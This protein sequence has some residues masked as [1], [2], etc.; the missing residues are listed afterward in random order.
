MAQSSGFDLPN[1]ATVQA[2][3]GKEANSVSG[4]P[5]YLA[6][7]NVHINPAIGTVV[8]SAGQAITGI[9]TD[10]DGDLRNA[11]TPDIGADEGNFTI[12][13]VNDM[14]ATAFVNP[15]NGGALGTS[16][17]S[18]Q[19]SFSNNGSATQ[20]SVTVR[21]RIIDSLSVEVYNQ[22]SVIASI[23][24][25]NTTVVTFPS[26]SL[27]IGTYTIKAKSELGTDQVL[28]NDEI[29]GTVTVEPPLTGTKTVGA[30][31]DFATLTAAFAKLNSVGIDR[32]VTLSLTAATYGVGETFPLVLNAVQGAGPLNTVTIKPASGNTVTITGSSTSC[33][34][35]LNGADYVTID[36]SNTVGG[37]TRDM[38]ITN[39]NTGTA[40]A[41]VCLTSLGAGL[42]AT[43]NVVKNV[44]LVGTSVTATQGTLAGVFAG[45][46][47]ISNT[48]AGADNDNNTIQNNNITKT[49]FGVYSGGAS[50][51][52]KNTGTL[53]SQNLMNSA[54]PTNITNG[55]VLVKFEDGVQIRNNS[56]SGIAFSGSFTSPCFGIALGATPSNTFTTFT[57]S[58]VTNAV[59][60]SNSIGTVAHT[61]TGSAYGIV[62]NA[63][64]SGTTL[65]ANNLISGVGIGGNPTPSD[66]IAGILAG[67]GTGSTTQVYFNSISLT[68]NQNGTSTSPS[69]G[70]AIA[71]GN[72]IV[73]V[74]NNI[75][76]NTQTNTTGTGKHYAIANASTTFTNMTSNYNDLFVSGA[77]GFI[78]QTNALGSTGTDRLDLAAWTAATGGDTP[79]TLSVDP[80]FTSATDLHLQSG[81]TLLG[82]GV[83]IPAVPVDFDGDTRDV[84]PDI[85]G[86]ELPVPTPP[87]LGNSNGDGDV[88]VND[89]LAVISTWG[90]CPNCPPDPCL[91]DLSPYPVGDCQVDVNDLLQVI[92]HWGAC[93]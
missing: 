8:E 57:G 9:T 52:N 86:D 40:T 78:G 2:L 15:T 64:T 17:F 81:S 38:T 49:V 74:K 62:V 19:A 66:F 82:M 12:I 10:I 11:T 77:T 35:N 59:V 89:L 54:S 29:S 85:G 90:A 4:N 70:L 72:P 13:L 71:S 24:G 33:M 39:T 67:G 47:T 76:Y 55:G 75:F 60:T 91:G 16:T 50:A 48:S 80:L 36:G 68:G 61:G 58:D 34:I 83:T 25:G 56:I 18:P 45:S 73:D 41:D 84:P 51:A 42:G 5:Q 65:V 20:T 23:A 26:T 37:S 3:T 88:D 43:N 30:G 1:L 53:I 14:Q 21:Y 79:N 93:P 31:G 32:P 92:S 87:C 69:Y 7:N 27:P 63:V 22:T 46:A 6:T 28:A 44:N